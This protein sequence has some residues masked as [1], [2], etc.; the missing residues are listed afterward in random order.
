MW[1]TDFHKSPKNLPQS[2][3][4]KLLILYQNTILPV[5]VCLIFYITTRWNGQV[6]NTC[7]HFFFSDDVWHFEDKKRK[8]KCPYLVSV[9]FNITL[10]KGQIEQRQA[11]I[12]D[13]QCWWFGAIL[14]LSGELFDCELIF[15]SM[16]EGGLEGTTWQKLNK[17]LKHE[18]KF[19]FHAKKD[20]FLGSTTNQCWLFGTK[21]ANQSQMPD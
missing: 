3:E 14:N 2:T 15:W 10:Q 21:H 5:F 9:T 20:Q 18:R 12:S 1:L 6:L 17:T 13:Q 16:G 4:Q 19:L 11:K 8:W 7:Y